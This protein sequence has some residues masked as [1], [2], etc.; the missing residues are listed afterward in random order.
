MSHVAH[1]T[2]GRS[3]LVV[4]PF[5]LGTMTF[6]TA[7]WGSD[8]AG[9]RAVF[10]AFLEAG[11]TAFD[12]ADVYAGGASEELL[13]KLIAERGNRDDVV[14]ATKAGF[15]TG[16]GVLGGGAS[17]RHL[18]RSLDASLARLG[19]DYVDMYWLH[20]WDGV[21]PASELVE[22]MATLVRSGR[23]RYWGISDAPAWFVA[24]CV[25]TARERGLPGPIA[26]QYFYSLTHR[27]VEYE[28][29]PLALEAELGFVPWSPLSYGLLTGKYERGATAE[30]SGLPNERGSGVEASSDRLQ[31]PNPF[32]GTRRVTRAGRPQVAGRAAGRRHDAHGS[33]PRGAGTF[34]RAGAD[35]RPAAGAASAPGRSERARARESVVALHARAA[36]QCG[37]RWPHRAAAVTDAGRIQPRT[38]VSSS[39][40]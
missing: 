25:A 8:E 27:E 40:S 28:H 16:S 33:E 26:M 13:G 12:T 38:A 1:R 9:S 21:T 31:G 15:A 24:L 20:I 17:A 39:V 23:T 35:P 7:R 34:Q 32:G 3:G 30:A 22:T 18:T 11:G 10:D 6:G 29:V 4:S 36:T 19:M 5:T 2:L 14:V 37:V